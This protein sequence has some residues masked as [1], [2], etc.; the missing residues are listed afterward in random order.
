MRQSPQLSKVV[1]TLVSVAG[2]EKLA[3]AM[4]LVAVARLP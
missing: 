1:L 3:A 2:S 4:T